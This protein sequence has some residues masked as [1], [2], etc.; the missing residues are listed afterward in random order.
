MT[1][2]ANNY[3]LF[4]FEDPICEAV[5]TLIGAEAILQRE[6]AALADLSIAIRFTGG[7]AT[8]H[9]TKA[10]DGVKVYDA[11]TG[12]SLQIEIARQRED[13]ELVADLSPT[14]TTARDTLS[15]ITGQIR[16]ALRHAK[17]TPADHLPINDEMV[18]PK[19]THFRPTQAV[20]AHDAEY[21]RDYMVLGWAIDYHIPTD[22]WPKVIIGDGGYIIT[23]DDG[24]QLTSD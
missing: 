17:V 23:G 8:G 18:S 10:P 16:H 7:T 13:D 19:I 11:Y 1:A 4:N 9:I 20:S 21:H 14:D 5:R 24:S 2:P 12:G 22:I 6:S 3:E 15:L